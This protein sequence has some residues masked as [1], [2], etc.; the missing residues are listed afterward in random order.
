MLTLTLD[1]A[2][3]KEITRR[4]TDTLAQKDITL[5]HQSALQAM[6]QALFGKPYEEIKA[7]LLLDSAPAQASN[8]TL[9]H[10][11][12]ESILMLNGRYITGAFPGTDLETPYPILESQ[13]HALAS[14]HD[15][16]LKVMTLPEILAPDFETDDVI[17][18]ANKMGF[19]SAHPSIF[20]MFDRVDTGEKAIF[21]DDMHCPFSLNSDYY[22]ELESALDEDGSEDDVT[23]WM[24][25]M[26]TNEGFFEFFV[27]FGQLCQA[28]TDDNGKTWV[29]SQ[30]DGESLRVVFR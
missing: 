25:E 10:Y 4:L 18:L 20:E 7:T 8:V 26:S 16:T 1:E 27:T 2:R 3:F 6:S 24:P 5:K 30:P 22:S 29:V 21:L 17:A 11:R 12:G 23:I 13:G 9:I 14:S 19:L 15:T 28:T